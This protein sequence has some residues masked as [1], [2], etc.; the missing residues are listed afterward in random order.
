MRNAY[1]LL[2]KELDDIFFTYHWGLSLILMRWRLYGTFFSSK[3]SK[4]L[5]E[6]GP[7]EPKKKNDNTDQQKFQT[8]ISLTWSERGEQWEKKE[9]NVQSPRI[10]GAPTAAFTQIST[11]IF[12]ELSDQRE[13]MLLLVKTRQ[14]KK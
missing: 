7:K 10:S 14:R 9:E 5:W 13:C 8:K 6:N 4:A 3:V 2:P 1:F 12:A 11:A